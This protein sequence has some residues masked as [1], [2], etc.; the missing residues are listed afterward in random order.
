MI[1]DPSPK[2]EGLKQYMCFI[3]WWPGLHSYR[4]PYIPTLERFV[5]SKGLHYVAICEGE[6]EPRIL[7]ILFR[8]LQHM[9]EGVHIVNNKPLGFET[10]FSNLKNI[11]ERV[12][13]DQRS[14]SFCEYDA[15]STRAFMQEYRGPIISDLR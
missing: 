9:Y 10:S 14:G 15:N 13:Q 5:R 6:Q 4:I 12:V 3:L 2:I 11:G 1:F 8:K 7:E